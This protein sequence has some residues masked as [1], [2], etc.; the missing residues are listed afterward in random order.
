MTLLKRILLLYTLFFIIPLNILVAED[1]KGEGDDGKADGIFFVNQ[2]ML[3]PLFDKLYDLENNKEGKINI[4]HIGDSHIQADFFTNAIRESLQYKFGNG[5]FGFTFPYNLIGTNGP[6]SVKYACNAQWQSMRNV[7][8]VNDMGIGLSGIALYTSAEDFALQL[9]T[10]EGFEFNKI[11]VIY[12]TV[13]PQYKASLTAEPLKV[14][15]V[16]AVTSAT[17]FKYHK[18]VGGENLSVIARKH[19]STITQIKKANNL[20]SDKIRAGQTL[21]IPVKGVAVKPVV[22][23]LNLDIDSLDCIVLD[24]MPYFSSYKSDTA[25]NL[26]TLLP[27]GDR[28][29]YNLNG[30][31]IENDE[32]G[33]VYH[34]IGVNGAKLSDYAKYPLFF[35]QLPILAPDLIILSFGTNESFGRVSQSEYI[36]QINDFAENIRKYN[37]DAIILVMTPPPSMYRRTRPNTYILNYTTALTGLEHLPVW[38]LYTRMGGASGIAPKGQFA[39]MMDRRKIHYTVSGY[40]AQGEL[41]TSDFLEAYDN[42]KK[43]KKN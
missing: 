39:K 18:V 5:G 21:K 12:P 1:I 42:Y 9:Q 20:T 2:S 35:K 41:F 26:I 3:E 37:E 10:A 19:G 34:S 14:S 17:G 16:G 13:E 25:L 32:P 36:S 38:D 7:G 8:A 30:F 29:T 24:S 28:S 15:R 4:V 11:K 31:V 33:I 23:K 22:E 27:V 6:V 43:T 40:R